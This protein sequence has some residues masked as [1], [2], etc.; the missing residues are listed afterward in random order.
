MGGLD[1]RS[2]IRD[3]AA[4]RD[5]F[6]LIEGYW[7]SYYF[8]VSRTDT[9]QVSKDLFTVISLTEAGLIEC[10]IEDGAFTYLGWGFPIQGNHM[11]FIL[12]K[13]K[14]LNEVIV[15][16][17]NRPD[18][19]PPKLYG[20]IMCLSGGIEDDEMHQYPCAAKVAFRYLGKEDAVRETYKLK[21][22][23]DVHAFLKAKASYVDPRGKDLDDEERQIFKVISNVIPAGQVPSALRMQR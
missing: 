6:E 23:I 20:I 12:E 19:Q 11:Y 4:L 3:T 14:L 15:Y 18:R 7:Y 13:D 17:T 10:R 1:F 21:P 5:L 2:R 22:N 9:V 16:V 8:S